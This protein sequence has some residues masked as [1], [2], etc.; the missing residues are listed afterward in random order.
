MLVVVL[1]LW[2]F[3][4]LLFVL[5]KFLIESCLEFSSFVFF[6]RSSNSWEI[7]LLSWNVLIAYRLIRIINAIRLSKVFTSV[8]ISVHS[9]IDITFDW[10][11]NVSSRFM[12]VRVMMLEL[13]SLRC[14]DGS[15][16]HKCDD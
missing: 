7:R 10:G 6:L 11:K 12:M 2:L 3:S 15:D 13:N 4:L 8:F 16:E 1:L 9:V 5:I 14:G